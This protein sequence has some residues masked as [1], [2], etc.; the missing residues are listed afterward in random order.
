MLT[1]LVRRFLNTGAEDGYRF[2]FVDGPNPM[3]PAD[4]MQLFYWPPYLNY[5]PINHSVDDIAAA[6]RWLEDYLADNGPYDGVMMFSQGCTLGL[7]TIMHGQQESTTASPPFKF[8]I[9]IC[10][11]PS[12]EELNQVL[13]F[14]VQ[15]EAWK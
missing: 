1:A 14:T 8:A 3:P 5:W 15:S 2:D 7:S 11:L 9:F 13:G 4:G 6:R 12:L 10:G